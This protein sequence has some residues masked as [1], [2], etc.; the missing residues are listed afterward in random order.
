MYSKSSSFVKI[1]LNNERITRMGKLV[2][3]I[4]ILLLLC[5]IS[6]AQDK[7]YGIGIILGEPSGLSGKYWLNSTNALDFGLGFSFT[8]F[9]N[10]RIQLNCD[11]LWNNYNLLKTSEK[12]VIYYGP[13]IKIL[14]GGSNDA[15]LGVRGVAGVGWFIKDAPLDVYFEIAPVVY[16]IPGTILKIDGGI[17]AR[18]YFSD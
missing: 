5:T 2:H 18:Y 16:L 1:F 14:T 3:H 13:G 9:N 8:N 15:K 10:S 6:Q 12:F 4:I 11:Y 7:G 17:G